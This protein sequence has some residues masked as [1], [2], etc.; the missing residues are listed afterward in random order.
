MV[1]V[2]IVLVCFEITKRDMYTAARESHKAQRILQEQRRAA[3]P[4]ATLLIDAKRVWNLARQKNIGAERKPHINELMDI[5][6]GRV[7]DIVF[8]HDASRI[9]QTIVRW[10]S[11]KQREEVALEL[12]GTFKELSQNKYSKVSYNSGILLR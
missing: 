11:P 6:R 2:P 12:K 5:V 3:K 10:G 8:K 7:K 1:S 9:V 4:H